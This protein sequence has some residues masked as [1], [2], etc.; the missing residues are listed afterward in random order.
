MN[1]NTYF[2]YCYSYGKIFI[3]ISMILIYNDLCKNFKLL[4]LIY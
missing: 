1:K 3:F 4:N 2:M